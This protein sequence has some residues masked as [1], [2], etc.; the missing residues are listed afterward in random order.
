MLLVHLCK[1]VNFGMN[2][3][4]LLS[5]IQRWNFEVFWKSALNSKCVD[6]EIVFCSNNLQVKFQSIQIN[7]RNVE[8]PLT[9]IDEFELLLK[10]GGYLGLKTLRGGC[11]VTKA[12]ICGG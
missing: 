5:D 12:E 11:C 6:L 3:N 9:V 8:H 2:Q 7:S 1:M 10:S 4:N